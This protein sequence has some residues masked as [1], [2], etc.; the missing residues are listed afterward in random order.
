MVKFKVY[1]FEGVSRCQIEAFLDIQFDNSFLDAV[2]LSIEIDEQKLL[3]IMCRAPW[4]KS[5]AP[6]MEMSFV[7]W[8]E[9]V[10]CKA[11][12]SSIRYRGHF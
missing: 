6:G 4:S 9:R 2:A 5:V 8:F 10:F 3:G 12:P 11:L 1:V 7:G